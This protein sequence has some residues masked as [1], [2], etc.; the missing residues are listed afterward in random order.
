MPIDDRVDMAAADHAIDA[1]RRDQDADE[2]MPT[3]RVSRRR[4]STRRV[5]C[6]E[7][8]KATDRPRPHGHER[9]AAG[10]ASTSA[11]AGPR[12]PAQIQRLQRGVLHHPSHQLAER[13]ARMGREFGHQ[14][15][16]G[17]AGLGVDLEADE[18]LRPRTVVI[19]EI[20]PAHAP[21]AERAMRRKRQILAPVGKYLVKFGA[22]RRWLDPPGAYFAS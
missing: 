21:A 22:G 14:R 17:H 15:R 16:L 2:A 13:D 4:S 5:T 12:S 19:A 1:G 7:A 11:L 8:L 20:R 18:F 6:D 3:P 10:G 9:A